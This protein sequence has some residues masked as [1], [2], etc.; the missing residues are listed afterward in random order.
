MPEEKGRKEGRTF[1]L[2]LGK[3]FGWQLLTL[4]FAAL[5]IGVLLGKIPIVFPGSGGGISS[6]EAGSK[7]VDY[8]NTNLIQ[9]G[10]CSLVSVQETGGMYKVTTSYQGQQIPVYVTKDGK[11]MF[12][13][14]PIDLTQSATT[15]TQTPQ[16]I[17]KTA[18]PS[19][20]LYVMSFC[21]YGTQAETLMKPVFDILGSSADFKV[22]FI[23][24]VTGTTVDSVQSLHGAAEAKEDLRQVCITKYYD[25]KTYWNYLQTFDSNCPSLKTND[26]ALAACWKDAATKAGIDT[27]KIDTC[28]GSSD[29]LDLLK[30]DEQLATQN[31]ITG[32]P[33]LLIN[34]VQYGGARS[35]DAFK[36]GICNS[37]TTM[38][39]ACSQNITSTT[40]SSGTAAT[41]G[42]GS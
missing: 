14:G 10:T 37:F 18:K 25:A 5:F 40:A 28:S 24:S 41:G 23:A 16:E 29:A 39:T 12:V 7:V 21:P 1:K 32:S 20:E 9:S 3:T 17:P 31:G 36:Q 27:S 38:P 30:A 33:T 4:L 42:C 2:K 26:T 22:R 13:S 19:V 34:G 15:S 8:I 11:L 35:S 6:Q